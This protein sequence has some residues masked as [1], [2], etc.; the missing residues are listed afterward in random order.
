MKFG[1]SIQS[2]E[3]IKKVIDKYNQYVFIWW[4]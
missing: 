1:L 3:K 2:Y 4:I